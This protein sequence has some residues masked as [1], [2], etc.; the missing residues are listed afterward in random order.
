MCVRHLLP[1]LPALLLCWAPFARADE[2]VGLDDE[3]KGSTKKGEITERY[4]KLTSDAVGID[5]KAGQR[6]ELSV[7]VSGDDRAVGI[8]LWDADG[9]PIASSAL[10]KRAGFGG[11]EIKLSELNKGNVGDAQHLVTLS[12]KEA[13]VV[14]GEVPGTGTYAIR[15]Y[16]D[17]GGAYTLTAK[18]LS[19]VQDV[20]T[21]EKEL[22][23]A[24][25]RV[26]ELEKELK[27]A[28]RQKKPQ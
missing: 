14:I 19:K 21:I 13:R 12:K 10:P 18:N 1:V 7:K 24:K 4:E 23:A 6:V 15:V 26:E 11:G 16:S 28:R 22:R 8:I 9:T 2:S 27:E 25:E 5:L 20:D 17:V 3:Y